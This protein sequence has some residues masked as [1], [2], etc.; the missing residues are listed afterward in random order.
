MPPLLLFAAPWSDYADGYDVLQSRDIRESLGPA[1]ARIKPSF[2]PDMAERFAGALSNTRDI[3]P[4]LALRDHAT[5]HLRATLPPG[6]AALIPSAPVRYLPRE[7][8]GATLGAFYPRALAIGAIAGHSGAPQVQFPTPFGG[9]SL[10]AAPGS[11]RGLLDC[12]RKL[13]GAMS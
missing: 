7:V 8:D 2:A 3:G 6:R 13:I 9:L 4:A 12:A 10:I 5:A 11:D 1:L